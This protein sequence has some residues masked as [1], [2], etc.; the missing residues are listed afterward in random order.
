MTADRGSGTVVADSGG[1]DSESI[2]AS[3]PPVSGPQRQDLER[4][5]RRQKSSLALALRER[6]MLQLTLGHCDQQVA[7]S[8]CARAVDPGR[9]TE[10]DDLRVRSP[11]YRKVR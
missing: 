10:G 6:I 7:D 9:P 3:I 5:L 1:S 2:Y 4:W 11:E 8:L